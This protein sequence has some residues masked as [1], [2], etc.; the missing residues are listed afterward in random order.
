MLLKMYLHSILNKRVVLKYK[1]TAINSER[2][3][4]QIWFELA[5]SFDYIESRK[6]TKYR[7]QAS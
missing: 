4:V 1:F 2:K 6:T 5:Y 7:R 3:A